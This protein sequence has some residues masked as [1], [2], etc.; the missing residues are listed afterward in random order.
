MTPNEFAGKFLPKFVY[1]KAYAK[2]LESF[3]RKLAFEVIPLFRDEQLSDRGPEVREKIVR[4]L[5][6]TLGHNKSF[7]Q[8]SVP[9]LGGL[10]FDRP[11]WFGDF[12]EAD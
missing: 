5:L 6:A 1:S 12:K 11:D 4:M 8:F 7:S 2:G 9:L 3:K 10:R